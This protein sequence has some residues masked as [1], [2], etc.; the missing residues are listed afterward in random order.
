M[1]R[2]PSVE[3]ESPARSRHRRAAAA[4]R[5][6][7][8]EPPLRVA[9]R[10][11]SYGKI[12]DASSVERIA[13]IR[14][15]IPASEAK[16]IFLDLEIGQGAGFKALNLSTATVNRKAKQGETL[17]Q[18]EG[19]RVLGFAKLV[20]QLE[21]LVRECGDAADFDARAWMARWLNEPLPALGGLRPVDLMDTMEGQGLVASLIAK[22]ESGAFA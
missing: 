7:E 15:G 6:A 1:T 22:M 8:Q 18:E 12:F 17:T 14:R 10:I 5:S 21:A 20:G 3:P 2:A 16:R 19:E 11:L 13:M 4:K 9:E